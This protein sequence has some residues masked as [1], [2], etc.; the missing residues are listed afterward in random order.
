MSYKT[1]RDY[2]TE[3]QYRTI[4]NPNNEVLHTQTNKILI[5][6]LPLMVSTCIVIQVYT[7]WMF[8]NMI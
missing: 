6:K 3:T 5:I 2:Y 7:G 8:S 1:K 4:E